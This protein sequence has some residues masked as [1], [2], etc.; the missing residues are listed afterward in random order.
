MDNLQERAQKRLRDEGDEP[1]DL[2]APRQEGL[3]SLSRPISPPRKKSRQPPQTK[4]ASCPIQTGSVVS[5]PWQLTWIRDLPEDQNRD[6]ITLRDLLGDPLISECWEFNYLHD[7]PFLMESFDPDTRHLTKVH[8]VHG[9]WKQED[10]NRLALAEEASR[11]PNV[12]L[13]VAPM[14]EM[15]GTHHSKMMILLRHDQTAQVII[16]TANMIPKDWTNMT[17]AVWKS[18]LLPM[19][20]EGAAEDTSSLPRD[21][22]P[23]GSGETFKKDLISYL[24]S[25]DRRKVTCGP[26]AAELNKYD[27]SAVRAALIASVPGRHA[28]HDVSQTAWGWAAL[29][30]HLRELPVKDGDAEIVVQI[31]SIAT[32]GAKDDWLQKTL[33]ETLCKSTSKQDGKR[34]EFKVVFPTPD[35]IRQSLDGYA[36][37]GSI[38][39]R[40]QSAQQAKQLQYLQPLFH[41]WAND[42]PA[43]KAVPDNVTKH[44]GHRSRASPHIKTY[45]RYNGDSIDWALLT[46]A[47]LSKQAWGEATRQPS[48]EVRIS[49]WEIG[50][51]LWPD[52]ISPRAVMVPTF[53]TDTPDGGGDEDGERSLIGVRIPYNVPLQKY[54][55]REAPWVASMV[56]AEPDRHGQVWT[57]Y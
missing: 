48:G 14:P 19:L 36:S 37:G 50:V 40:I 41:H 23:I 44:D 38:H 52:L 33:F 13:H 12:Q 46:S 15:F 20:P 34:P 17:N 2:P 9:F 51:L 7:I 32:L 6:A 11:F 1:E 26:L 53:G 5:S 47:N 21:Q 4:V 8:V 24:R 43:G 49:S 31:S 54:G 10:P 56:H 22:Y 16:H 29:K 55:P 25:Y 39:T 45:I 27:F 35:E 42:S 30:Q 3:E 28:V 18:P 57:G